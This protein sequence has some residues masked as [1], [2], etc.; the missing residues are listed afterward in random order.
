MKDGIPRTGKVTT[1]NSKNQDS[2]P[3]LP[4]LPQIVAKSLREVYVRGV[5]EQTPQEQTTD[6]KVPQTLDL[7]L[8]FAQ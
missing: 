1:E 3:R 8:P 4:P 7:S 6:T 2:R 5:L